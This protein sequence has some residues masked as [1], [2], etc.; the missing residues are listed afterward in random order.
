MGLGVDVGIDA[1]GDRCDAAHLPGERV[2]LHQFGFG[3]D[4]ETTDTVFQAQ[5]QF[6]RSLSH[7]G[8]DNE[9][10]IAPCAKHPQQFTC[11]DNVEATTEPR[12]HLQHGQIGVRFNS[13]AHLM[14]D[15]R[16]RVIK[17]PIAGL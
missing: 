13:E 2:E 4:V 7:T 15:R 17:R 11:R 3:L 1:Q 8:E 6:G 14:F 5:T 10:G 16:E 9:R 12:Q